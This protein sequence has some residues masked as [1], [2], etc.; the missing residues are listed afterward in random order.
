MNNI[1]NHLLITFFIISPLQEALLKHFCSIPVQQFIHMSVT[2]HSYSD[3]FYI[4]AYVYVY[5]CLIIFILTQGH[6]FHCL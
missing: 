6:F 2:N 3:I 4:M 1:I 5:L